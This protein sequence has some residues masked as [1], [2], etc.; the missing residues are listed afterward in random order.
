MRTKTRALA[1][2]FF[3]VAAFAVQSIQAQTFMVLF[4][5]TNTNQGEQPDAGLIRDSAGN[6]YGTTQYGGTRGGYG[7][8]FRLDSQGN[9]TVLYSFAGEPD[10]EDPYAPLVA[11]AGE[12]LYGTTLYGGTAGGYGTAFQFSKAGKL[13]LLHSFGSNPGGADPYG[14]LVAGAPGTGY[15]TTQYGGDAGGFGTVFKLDKT[16]A[17]VI[18]SFGGTPDG[19]DPKAGLARDA[20]GNLYGTTEF[21]GTAGGFGTV[22]KL[23][24]KGKLTLLHSFAGTPDGENPFAGLVADSAGN[25]YGTTRYGGTAGGFGTVFKLD[26]TG[27][28][29]VLYSFAGNPDGENPLGPVIVDSAGNLYGTTY[30]G[31]T[32]GYGT[33]FKLDTGG[34]LTELHSFNESPDGGHPIGGLIMDSAGNLYGTTSDGGDLSCGF[35]GCGTIFEITP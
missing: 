17:T 24:P 10:G 18:Y 28:F 8:I 32:F 5:F 30:Y 26:R 15:G 14:A 13:T 2:A 34:K 6:L 35:F 33:A 25:G 19:E 4:T 12:N 7:T 16:G 23:D 29:S 11:D 21:G 9:E 20:F 1:T 22:F 3:M 27:R 31:G